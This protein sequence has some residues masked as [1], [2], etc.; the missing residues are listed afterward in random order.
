MVSTLQS[1][2]L[3]LLLAWGTK[4]QPDLTAAQLSDPMVQ[5]GFRYQQQS[6]RASL[7]TLWR[8]APST[9]CSC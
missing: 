4:Q 5:A 7:E 3:L 8:H 1:N 2:C 6:I 9:P